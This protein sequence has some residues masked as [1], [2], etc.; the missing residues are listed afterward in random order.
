MRKDSLV[1]MSISPHEQAIAYRGSPVVGELETQK[2]AQLP[3]HKLEGGEVDW[4]V[5]AFVRCTSGS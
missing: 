5:R 3:A 2:V 1:E 4:S